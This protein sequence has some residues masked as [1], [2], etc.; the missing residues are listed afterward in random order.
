MH[1]LSFDEA[2]LRRW[3]GHVF[4]LRRPLDFEGRG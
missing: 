1:I 4:M 3:I 2:L